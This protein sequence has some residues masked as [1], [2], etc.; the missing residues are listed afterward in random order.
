MKIINFYCLIFLSLLLALGMAGC[1]SESASGEGSSQE[2]ITL[3]YAFFA[4]AS[5]F[6]GV[7][8][9][10]WAEE[11]HERSGG[12]VKVDLFPGGALLEASNMFDGVRDGVADIGLTATS[13]EPDRYPLL[14]ISDLPSGY[15]NASVASRVVYDLIREYPPEALDD[16]KIITAFTSEPAYVQT[17][18]DPVETLADFE[19]KELRIAGAVTEIAKRLGAAPVAMPQPE[20]LQALQTGVIDGYITSREVLKDFQLGEMIKYITDYPM[21]VTTF[22]AVMNNEVWE[23]LPEEIQEIID[24]LGEEMATFTGE[25]HDQQIE[26]AVAWSMEEHGTEM[27]TLSDEEK[28]RWD[29]IIGPMQQEYVAKLEQQGYPAQEYYDRLYELIETYS[30]Q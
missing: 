17:A 21:H 27:V 5:S 18:K 10:K 11:L 20:V 4:P 22:V 28:E 30:Q 2:S 23:S 16:F 19:G 8:M 25:Y 12:R 24:Q 26:E 9:E 6:P 7:Q 3:S 1:G 15:P 13:Y 14:T 29:A